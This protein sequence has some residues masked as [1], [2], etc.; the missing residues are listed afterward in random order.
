MASISLLS[1]SVREALRR[2]SR[3]LIGL[4]LIGVAIALALSLATWNIQ[5]PS[6]SHATDAR[7]RNKLGYPG[8]M[9]A[10]LLMQL[11][12]T[13]SLV[14]VL[15][16]AFWGWRIASHRTLARER[17]RVALW[18]LCVPLAA[19]CA[20]GLPRTA[21]WPLPVGLG[22]VLG[23][24]LIQLCSYVAGAPLSGL[25]KTA[26]VFGFG[27]S[28]L[29]CLCAVAGAGFHTPEPKREKQRKREEPKQEHED[30]P[31]AAWISLGWLTHAI[32]VSS[33]ACT[34]CSPAS[35]RSPSHHADLLP[36]AGWS[37]ASTR[38]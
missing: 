34:G 32:L 38:T 23:E 25:F 1:D 7:V 30:E 22:G 28:A 9:V 8:A 13:A 12:G 5:D 31:H 18:L 24:W 37:R 2:R 6:L 15:P 27:S 14:L 21:S 10:D 3:E 11:L 36:R 20:A 17:I 29:V 33:R 26:V 16:I 4:A 35:A 19:A